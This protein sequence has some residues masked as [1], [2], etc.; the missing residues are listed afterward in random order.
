MQIIWRPAV[1]SAWTVPNDFV[2]HKYTS[3]MLEKKVRFHIS[4]YLLKNS[5]GV[6]WIS[7]CPVNWIQQIIDEVDNFPI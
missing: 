5:I 2:L 7:N 6:E 4:L 3:L 1:T